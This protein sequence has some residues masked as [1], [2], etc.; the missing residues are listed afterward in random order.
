MKCFDADGNHS[1]VNLLCWEIHQ[2][3]SLN[4]EIHDLFYDAKLFFKVNALSCRTNFCCSF[5][6]FSIA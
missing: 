2:S 6:W 4:F 3:D 1:L 5:A